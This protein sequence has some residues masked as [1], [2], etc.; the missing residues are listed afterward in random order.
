MQTVTTHHNARGRFVR[1]PEGRGFSEH[2]VNHFHY[3][4]LKAIDD[5]LEEVRSIA[6]GPSRKVKGQ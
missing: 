4:Y 3:P 2:A 5:D 6:L 1:H